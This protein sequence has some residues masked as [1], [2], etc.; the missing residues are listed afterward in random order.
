MSGLPEE[1]PSFMEFQKNF[2]HGSCLS[3]SWSSGRIQYYPIV[4]EEETVPVN[5]DVN[6]YNSTVGSTSLHSSF[7][8]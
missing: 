1:K 2:A 3:I 4:Y 5:C 6:M 7:F 8:V